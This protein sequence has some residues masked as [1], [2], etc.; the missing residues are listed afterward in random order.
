LSATVRNQPPAPMK[1]FRRVYGQ[2]EP[3]GSIA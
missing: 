2:R 1:R 3:N